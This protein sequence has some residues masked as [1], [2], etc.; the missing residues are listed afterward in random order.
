MDRRNGTNTLDGMGSMSMRSYASRHEARVAWLMD[1]LAEREERREIAALLEE[2]A[3]GPSGPGQTELA[4]V[5][6]AMHPDPTGRA[7]LRLWRPTN[8]CHVELRAVCLGEAQ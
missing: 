4:I 7:A 8:H 1:R 3:T 6:L 2:L 5:E